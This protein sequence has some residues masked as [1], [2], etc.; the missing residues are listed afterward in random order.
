[1][2]N[3]RLSDVAKAANVS[4]ATV[5]RVMNSSGYVADG[6]KAHVEHVASELGYI[7]PVKSRKKTSQNVIGVISN[8]NSLSPYF[9][10]LY[11]HIQKTAI[12]HGYYCVEATAESLDDDALAFHATELLKME[13]SAL[14]IMGYLSDSL[15][16]KCRQILNNSSVPVVFLERTADCQGFHRIFVDNSL[17]TYEATKYL[18]EQGHTHLLYLAYGKKANEERK[19]LFGF[20]RAIDTYKKMS[21]HK[22]IITTREIAP[23]SGSIGVL[24]ALQEDPEITAIVAWN[25]IL[26]SGAETALLS[27]GKKIPEDIE[28]IGCDNILAP[29]LPIP[30]PSIAM[31]LAEI[32]SA[33]LEI[34][35]KSLKAKQKPSPRTLTLEPALS[36]K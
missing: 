30:I 14:I 2:P 19:R 10:T 33:A 16:Q 12:L 25:D 5:S 7:H 23:R 22:T 32:A 28:L 18:L 13:V 17:G 31:P 4:L 15:N 24:K 21:I 6:V 26:A 35:D 36:L 20:T 34:I 27:I 8:Y 1:M 3:I 11:H 9:P 29:Y